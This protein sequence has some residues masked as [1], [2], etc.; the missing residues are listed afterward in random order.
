MCASNTLGRGLCAAI[1]IIA[2]ASN[3][4]AETAAN[5]HHVH[6][7]VVNP[8]STI[9][10]YKK[11]FSG[12]P[13]KFRGVSD[14]VFVDRSFILL[15]KVE[16]PAS[17]AQQTGI[18]HIGW[19]GVDGPGEFEWRDEE[20]IEWQRELS[21]LGD[22]YFMYAY[23]PD[24]EIVEVYTGPRHNRFGHV[25]LVSDDVAATTKWFMEHLGLDGPEKLPPRPALSEVK[26]TNDVIFN[27]FHTPVPGTFNWAGGEPMRELKKSD[28]HV[29]DHI[30]FS[31]RDID[32]AFARMNAA[33]VEIVEPITYEETL[34]MRHFF[35]RSPDKVLVEIVEAKPIP[36][37]VWGE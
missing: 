6:L 30:A 4:S 33:G 20:G 27:I 21:P 11:F 25:H 18:A 23:G 9:A 34:R 12:V 3:V 2:L 14:A 17:S 8:E 19:F 10:Y 16:T 29:I 37:G 32:A 5:F 26:T 35:I 15:N 7:N 13:V 22:E 24:K 36:S 28:G 31:Y 1:S